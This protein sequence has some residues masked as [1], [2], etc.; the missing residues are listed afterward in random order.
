ML[1]ELNRWWSTVGNSAE[2]FT[3]SRVERQESSH[4]AVYTKRYRP[5]RHYM[6]GPGPMWLEKHGGG[7]AVV[8]FV[9]DDNRGDGHLLNFYSQ[10]A[11]R[12]RD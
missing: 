10:L 4:E 6:R 12:W 3:V 2:S 11:R 8:G 7:I 9:M 5:E 1:S